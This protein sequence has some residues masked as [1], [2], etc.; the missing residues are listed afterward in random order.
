[1]D[2]WQRLALA[3]GRPLVV[4]LQ[5]DVAGDTLDAGHLAMQELV[6]RVGRGA[7]YTGTFELTTRAAEAWRSADVGLADPRH[8]RL[9][10]VECW[11]TIGDIGAAVRSSNR[12]RAELA[13]L[14]IAR[15]G[16]DATVGLVWVVRASSRNRALVARYPEVFAR[17]FPGSSRAWLAAL[18]DGATPP[19]DAGLV[20]SDV[21]ATRLYAWRRR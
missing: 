20:W 21:P 4:T 17:A 6:L 9:I 13:D 11:N 5:Q 16:E 15:G 19:A 3:V 1:M 14:A 2:A 12:K 8:R 18:S 10:H 7:G